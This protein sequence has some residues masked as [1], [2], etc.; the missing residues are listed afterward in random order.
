MDAAGER[1]LKAASS[2]GHPLKTPGG[3]EKQSRKVGGK[4]EVVVGGQS[5]C[6]DRIVGGGGREEGKKG[7]KQGAAGAEGGSTSVQMCMC[8]CMCLRVHVV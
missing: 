3:D 8:A 1:L 7:L 2:P 4:V 5:D 6:I